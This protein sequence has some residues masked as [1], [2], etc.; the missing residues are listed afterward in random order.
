M[1]WTVAVSAAERAAGTM[2]PDTERLALATLREQ[3]CVL[4][5]GAF[6]PALIDDLA[7]EFSARYG[8]F[9]AK[10][11]AAMALTPPPNP[12]IEVGDARFEIAISMSG[13]FARPQVF[14]N[15][16]LHR[17][18]GGVLG[19][20]L[21]LSGFTAVV[22]HPGAGLQHP[23]RD[24]RFLFPGS[25]QSNAVPTYAINVS[26][27]LID[28]DEATGPT[29]IWPGSHKWAEDFIPDYYALNVPFRRGDAVLIDYRTLHTGLP[30]A[31]TRVR[32]ILY[33]VYARTWFFDDVN[34]I[35]RA[36]LDMTIEQFAQMPHELHP[37]LS[38]A[39]SQAMR[40]RW[41]SSRR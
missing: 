7:R 9:D 19:E 3:G 12:L 21:R 35:G 20:D 15:P 31:G 2:S 39:Y 11:M 33:M 25:A 8:A 27:P 17:F 32:P 30:N 29:A 26:V 6:D 41:A 24:H 36:A 37:L 1:T 13:V 38:R 22:S 10:Q 16:L 4:L 14:A 34:H 28:V 18:L 40:A 5:R 23:H